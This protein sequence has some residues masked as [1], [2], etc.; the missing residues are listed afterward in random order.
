MKNL[1]SLPCKSGYEFDI[2]KQLYKSFRDKYDKLRNEYGCSWF[3]TVSKKEYDE[4]Q[5]LEQQYMK[6]LEER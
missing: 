3:L 2:D 4:Y 6:F 1:K 5:I